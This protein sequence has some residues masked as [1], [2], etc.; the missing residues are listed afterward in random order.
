[1]GGEIKAVD[2]V[3]VIYAI[4][5]RAEHFAATVS[6]RATVAEFGLIGA[7]AGEMSGETE[8]FLEDAED[9]LGPELVLIDQLSANFAP[10]HVARPG[11]I[12]T[13]VHYND[14][15]IERAFRPSATVA[16]VTVWAIGPDGF[17]LS[18]SPADFQLKLEGHVLMPDQ[19][20]GQVAHGQKKLTLDLVFKIKPQG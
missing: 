17:K 1:M 11:K 18:G 5:G 19:H 3:E 7:K 4:E 9:P 15:E 16:K 10:I 14:Q 6:T 13:T 20:L 12:A 2:A 8:V